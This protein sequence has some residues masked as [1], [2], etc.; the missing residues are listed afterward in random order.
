[1]GKDY[2]IGYKFTADG[3]G[4]Q[5]SVGEMNKSLNTIKSNTAITAMNQGMK[6]LGDS[7]KDAVDIYKKVVASAQ[8]TGDA[9][10]V[11][12]AG[13]HEAA[14]TLMQNMATMDFSVSLKQA[15]AAAEEYARVLD[16]LGD[17]GRSIKMISSETKFHILEL[18]GELRNMNLSDE[19]RLEIGKQIN[20]LIEH[21]SMLRERMLNEAMQGIMDF[22]ITKFGITEEQARLPI[23]YVK[24]YAEYSREQQNALE[25]AGKKQLELNQWNRIGLQNAGT[26]TKFLEVQKRLTEELAQK[27]SLVPEGLQEFIPIWQ[28]INRMTDAHRDDIAKISNEWWDAKSALQ[29]YENSADWTTNRLETQKR[30]LQTLKSLY[31]HTSEG[32][33]FGTTKKETAPQK[34]IQ[35]KGIGQTSLTSGLPGIQEFKDLGTNINAAEG[36]LRKLL[37]TLQIFKNIYD[38]FEFVT[39]SLENL[40]NVLAQGADDFRSYGRNIIMTIKDI[41]KAYFAEALAAMITNAMKTAAKAGPFALAAAPALA[42]LAVGTVST[43]F[44]K[45]TGF[46]GGTNYAPGGLALVGERGPE[47]VNLPRGSQVIPNNRIGGGG[48]ILLTKLRGSDIDIVLKRH[49]SQIQTNT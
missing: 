24:N 45:I 42:A 7:L 49:Y 6:L 15:R 33:L 1:M 26:H 4:F 13:I 12:M 25:E 14:N 47:L 35:G 38:P 48:D 40:S 31:S 28:V 19:K 20:A 2:S 3:K 18:R 34:D 8:S 46:A 16:D 44:S 39:S 27:T 23:E 30:L 11:T 17:R 32:Y 41:V 22:D 21:E 10:E 9:F 5:R 43:A 36:D 37:D 29:S